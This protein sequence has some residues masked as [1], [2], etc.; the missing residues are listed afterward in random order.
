[1]RI[2]FS[3]ICLT[4]IGLS[5][6]PENTVARTLA[7]PSLETSGSYNNNIFFSSRD[8]E[9]DFIASV[10]PSL[11]LAVKTERFNLSAKPTFALVRYLDNPNLS[12]D[13]EKYDIEMLARLSQRFEL[14][15]YSEY[16]KDSTQESEQ[17][18]TGTVG[19]LSD[20]YRFFW[21]GG[22]NYLISE[23]TKL[24]L[25]YNH[26]ATSYDLGENI[27][28]K[29][30]TAAITGSHMMKDQKTEASLSLSFSKYVS[31][32]NKTNSLDGTLGFARKITE[33]S[34]IK[35][36]LG[37]RR[38]TVDLDLKN[39]QDEGSTKK[40]G[41]VFSFDLNTRNEIVT[42]KLAYSRNLTHDSLGEPIERDQIRLNNYF[43]TSEL[44]ALIF[45][46]RVGQ[47]R[48]ESSSSNQKKT[49]FTLTPSFKYIFSKNSNL[50]FWYSYA[51]NKT[52]IIDG[53]WVGARNIIWVTYNL[54]FPTE[55]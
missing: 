24:K 54:N 30:N 34:S 19:F 36:N 1:M 28:W 11:D 6:Q 25:N 3:A 55:L 8:K 43:R 44:T 32:A 15:A 4:I 13:R 14:T 42:T 23:A 27:D 2:F 18:E 50:R 5:T 26:S 49:D 35:A 47:S 48:S 46:A 9:D 17:D 38:T 29:F 41:G 10:A 16:K 53:D 45:D 22:T 21:S 7:S 20:R 52:K 51:Y 31:D 39:T 40:W 33:R 37:V 12:R